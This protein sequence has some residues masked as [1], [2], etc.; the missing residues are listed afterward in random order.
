MESITSLLKI[1]LFECWSI[2]LTSLVHLN[3]HILSLWQH[4]DGTL[5]M[6]KL[7]KAIL[8]ALQESGIVVDEAELSEALEQKV[9]HLMNCIFINFPFRIIIVTVINNKYGFLVK[10]LCRQINSSSRF[11]VENKYVRLLAKDWT[12]QLAFLWLGV[13]AIFIFS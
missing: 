6:K 10:N 1:C 5:K 7:R 11:A 9:S 2:H 12:L 13:H 8:K 4:P 3:V